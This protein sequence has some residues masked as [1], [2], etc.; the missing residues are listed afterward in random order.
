MERIRGGSP[1]QP[2]GI[3]KLHAG[4]EKELPDSSLLSLFNYDLALC[5]SWFDE[6]EL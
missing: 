1:I 4:V 2:E 3:F 5:L 6:E